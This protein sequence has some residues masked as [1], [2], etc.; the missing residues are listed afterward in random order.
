M[1]SKVIDVPNP[2][3]RFPAVHRPGAGIRNMSSG[4]LLD[5]PTN[6][7]TAATNKQAASPAPK[8]TVP[9]VL[10]IG[11]NSSSSRFAAAVARQGAVGGGAKQRSSTPGTRFAST[12]RDTGTGFVYGSSTASKT[13]VRATTTNRRSM[14]PNLTSER[15]HNNFDGVAP[16]AATA[17]AAA[18]RS[19]T[20]N[21]GGGK[22]ILQKSEPAPQV[23][24]AAVAQVSPRFGRH[25]IHA[26]RT[27]TITPTDY[28]EAPK[29]VVVA[30]RFQSRVNSKSLVGVLSAAPKRST[31][32]HTCRPPF[33]TE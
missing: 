22:R 30:Q 11:A 26:E 24:A 6:T 16:A 13:P 9:S 33:W 32:P 8:C 1:A 4:M 5:H 2:Y 14:T 29:P 28:T 3:R 19:A 31:T 15:R 12:P 18:R 21:G 25:V 17:G 20:P 10:G 27:A 7:T 23:K